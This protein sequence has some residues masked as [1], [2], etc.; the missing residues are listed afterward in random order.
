M[1]RIAIHDGFKVVRECRPSCR[2]ATA[3]KCRCICG[4]VFHGVGSTP[5]VT[6][7]ELKYMEYQAIQKATQ[8]AADIDEHFMGMR[9]ERH[10]V[11]IGYNAEQQSLFSQEEAP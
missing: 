5:D 7:R 9:E 2:T 11:V 6:H 10:K 4:G 1:I 8:R 3:S